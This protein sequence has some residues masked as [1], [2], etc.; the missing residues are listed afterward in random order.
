MKE[1]K[2]FLKV[3]CY[4]FLLCILAFVIVIAAGLDDCEAYNTG[5]YTVSHGKI[6][7][8]LG[9]ANVVPN[10]GVPSYPWMPD[11]HIIW[12]PDGNN[13]QMYWPSAPIYR[14]VGPDPLLEAPSPSTPVISAG[15]PGSFDNG[16]AWLMSAFRQEGNNLI[17]TYHA[18]DHEWLS[19]KVW[20]NGVAIAWSSIALCT[21]DDNG[22]SWTKHGQILTAAESKPDVAAWSG[23]G[24][25]Q[26]VYDKENSRWIIFFAQN[27]YPCIAMSEDPELKPGTWFKYKNGSFSEPGI[28]GEADPME[29]LRFYGGSGASIHFNY[30]LNKWV[31]RQF[32]IMRIILI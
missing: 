3:I 11:G 13:Y 7:I 32:S 30:C 5:T 14:T 19:G 28:G 18:E 22:E 12:L 29:G 25:G 9:P 15:P 4:I 27:G 20:D 26:V 8:N 17:G 24:G 1:E 10:P 16:G 21:S 31:S 6:D 2:G 23:F